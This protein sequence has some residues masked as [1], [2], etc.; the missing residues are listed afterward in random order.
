VLLTN[1]ETCVR[2][3]DDQAVTTRL[4]KYRTTA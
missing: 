2:D 4:G 1:A 3:L